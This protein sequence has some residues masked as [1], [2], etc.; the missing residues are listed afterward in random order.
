MTPAQR[1]G[2]GRVRIR[3]PAARPAYA[4]ECADSLAAR[5]AQQ[6]KLSSAR[7]A[8]LAAAVSLTS[9]TRQSD[10]AHS[11]FS[12][13]SVSAPRRTARAADPSRTLLM[14]NGGHFVGEFSSEFLPHGEGAA[15][16]ADG[17]ESASGQWRNGKLHGRGKRTYSS[18]DRYEGDFVAGL[19]N[20]LGTATW[21]HGDVFEGEWAD[22]KRSGFGVQWNKERKVAHCGRWANDQSLESCP[23]P[24]IKMPVGKFLSAAGEPGRGRRARTY[25]SAAWRVQFWVPAARP[26]GAVG[27]I[28]LRP[29][30]LPH[31]AGCNEAE[32]SLAQLATAVIR[33]MLLIQRTLSLFPSLTVCFSFRF[34]AAANSSRR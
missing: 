21:A 2:L 3:V 12:F 25:S 5:A 28:W 29:T 30:P 9:R 20:G 23:V 33:R 7:P 32:L 11:L 15:F 6:L 26:A 4:A 22:N 19:R 18:G 27:C 13:P 24:R 1:V 17:S 16:Y 34:C 10:S 14:H 31:C 8:Q